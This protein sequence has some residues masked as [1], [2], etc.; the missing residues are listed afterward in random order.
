[1][2]L[3]QEL[4]VRVHERTVQLEMT[5]GELAMAMEEA[6]SANYAKSAFL[7]SMSHELRTPLNAILGFAQISAPTAC[8]R[9]WRKRRNS[10]ATS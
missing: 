9:P 8:R 1:M 5:N 2:R 7:S 3:N 6:R 4:E 10:P